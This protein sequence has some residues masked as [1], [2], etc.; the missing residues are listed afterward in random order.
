MKTER[1]YIEIIIV[2]HNLTAVDYRTAVIS[3]IKI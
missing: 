2:S 1:K 3:I